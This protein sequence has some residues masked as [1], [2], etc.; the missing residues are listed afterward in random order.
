MSCTHFGP[1]W[2]TIGEASAVPSRP[3]R[4]E[5]PTGGHTD[6]GGQETASETATR[7]F[8]GRE[9]RGAR[10]EDRRAAWPRHGELYATGA[11]G[12]PARLRA[13]RGAARERGGAGG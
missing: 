5:R 7:G 12:M 13:A 3:R 9:I 10:G 1:A 8:A 11:K 2:T 4:S 6:N